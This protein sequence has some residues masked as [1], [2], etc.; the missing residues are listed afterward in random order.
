MNAGG[1]VRAGLLAGLLLPGLGAGT[2][3]VPV[4]VGDPP[5]S[6]LVRVQVP[7]VS[8][9]TGFVVA[10]DLVVTAA[11]CLWSAR[12]GRMARPGRV[13]VLAGYDRGTFRAHAVARSYRVGE[14]FDG[15]S[16]AGLGGDVAV[17]ALDAPVGGPSLPWAGAA[18]PG[19]A[20]MLGGYEQDRSE[21]LLADTDCRVMGR[22]VDAG[23][24]ALLQHACAATRGASGAP[25]LV[26]EGGVWAVAGVNV[27]AS[28]GDVGGL[29]VPGATARALLR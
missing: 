21:A 29:A 13:H 16:E 27:A 25:L 7:G 12:V 28:V 23:G 10:R 8:R 9:C 18:R 11:H 17:L 3:R 24:R 5:W 22:V 20:A 15:R 14:G 2:V 4:S 26:R 1:R 19:Q 6:S